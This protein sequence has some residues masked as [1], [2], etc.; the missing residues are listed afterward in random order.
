[1]RACI[2]VI[3]INMKRGPI[4]FILI[5]LT[6]LI[7]ILG[8]QYGKTVNVADEAFSLL[9]SITPSAEPPI[10]TQKDSTYI[11][12]TNDICNISFLYPDTLTLKDASTEASLISSSDKNQFTL[13]CGD[14]LKPSLPPSEKTATRSVQLQQFTMIG[15]NLKDS[16]GTTI[17]FSRKHP[18]NK[19]TISVTVNENLLPLIEKTFEFVK[20]L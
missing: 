16:E 10:P 1:M 19:R 15:E 11:L 12:Y 13:D 20:P 8:V 5:L 14:E 3:L 4:L 6:T 9:M 18:Y 17:H 7:F 2:H